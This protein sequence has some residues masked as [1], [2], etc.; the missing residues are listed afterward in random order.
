MKL[1]I[2]V[3][4][5]I[6]Y[7]VFLCCIL[8][9][10]EKD[11][12]RTSNKTV[13]SKT[14]DKSEIHILVKTVEL[15]TRSEDQV[16]SGSDLKE[17]AQSEPTTG[18]EKKAT[19]KGPE[20]KSLVVRMIGVITEEGVTAIKIML[21]LLAGI[22]VVEE[23]CQAY[24]IGLHYFQEM[25]NYIEWITIICVFV[26]IGQ[27]E[28]NKDSSDIARGFSAIGICLAYLELIFLLGRYPFKWCD[29]GIM[30]YRI[31]TRLLR[32]V[33]ALLLIIIGHAFAFT[34]NMHSLD[35]F[36]SPW[37]SFVT[38]LTRSNVK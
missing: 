8:V 14:L 3:A 25:E 15:T 36:Q 19:S 33:F 22:L 37:K 20:K 26:S 24:T 29:F 21:G 16:L 12:R 6:L 28:L 34:V 5:V 13:Y 10:T 31:L 18:P 32:Y 7:S 35:A 27:R 2:F 23:L 17:D 30:F 4:F 1:L 9:S 38:T 11:E